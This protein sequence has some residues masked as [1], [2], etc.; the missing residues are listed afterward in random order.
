[1]TF[2][3]L[4]ELLLNQNQQKYYLFYEPKRAKRM[5]LIM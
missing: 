1:M 2:I 3:I 4:V 5:E